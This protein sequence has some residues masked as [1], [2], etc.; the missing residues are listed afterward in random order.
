MGNALEFILRLKNMLT[1]EMRNAA[2]VSNA[3]ATQIQ[4]NMSRANGS[5]RQFSASL[6]EL[7]ARLAAVNRTR[8]TT[9]LES[10]F[11]A[12][13]REAKNLQREIDRI[14]NMGSSGGGIW[15]DIK[16]KIAGIVTVG[17]ALAFATSSISAAMEF[18]VKNKSYEVLAGSAIRGQA[19]SSKLLDLKQN[20]IMGTSVYQ[21]AQT[22][23]G[24]G[25]GDREVIK[26]LKMI[27]DISMGNVDRMSSLTLAF[28]QTRA[29]GKLMG[30]DLLQY[31]NAG[32]NPLS[33]IS[34]HWKQFGLKH[35]VTVGQLRE[36]MSKGQITSAAIAK[37]FEVATSAGGKFYGMM[38]T[39]AAT[40][41]G[42]LQL[43][44]GHYAAF[45]IQV[46]QSF[47]PLTN[48]LLDM[49][50]AFMKALQNG[51]SVGDQVNQQ[52]LTIRKLQTELTNTNTSQARRLELMKQLSDINPNL[53]KGINAEAIEY[54]KLADNINKVIVALN[55]KRIAST[56]E[57]AGADKIIKLNKARETSGETVSDIISLLVQANPD[58]ATRNDL[59]LGQK[60]VAVEKYLKDKIRSGKGTTVVLHSQ[61][62]SGISPVSTSVKTTEEQVLLDRMKALTGANKTA[63]KTIETLQPDVSQM[64][65]Q[66]KIATDVYNKAFDFGKTTPV[67]HGKP[68]KG[69][70][71]DNSTGGDGMGGDDGEF[72]TDGKAKK[73]SQGGQRSVIINIQKQIEHLELHVMSNQ[74]AGREMESII[75][76]SLVRVLHSFNGDTNGAL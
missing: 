42:K 34:E 73:I 51:K 17:A 13:T 14:N 31:V 69:A 8:A 70:I 53:T 64:Q 56:I 66:I 12:A 10:D 33:V 46:G 52:I 74:D 24:F 25:V 48:S 39:I 22:L 23:M 68:A 6:S 9:R 21:N 71:T 29:A 47:L 4:N 65:K 32:F 28:A 18:Q 26:D 35:A 11:K 3:T 54:G 5:S 75:R 61:N 58:I 43:L 59:S 50:S 40:T 63:N 1:P 19:L 15:S 37:A 7:S 16:G 72:F 27:G 36:M 49:A 20:T 45:Q 30:Q 60:Q 67:K 2:Q 55:Q 76:E 41:A 57:L 44:K 38:D 62:G